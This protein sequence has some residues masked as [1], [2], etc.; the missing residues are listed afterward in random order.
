MGMADYAV[1]VEYIPCDDAARN[2][3]WFELCIHFIG[4]PVFTAY[5]DEHEAED[6]KW[7]IDR[8]LQ[9]QFNGHKDG[10]GMVFL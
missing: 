1:K 9:D 6:L 3:E 8:A 10:R 7:Q 4:G 5:L 2:R